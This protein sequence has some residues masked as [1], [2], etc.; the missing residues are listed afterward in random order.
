MGAVA[1]AVNAWLPQDAVVYCLGI[2]DSL[3]AF[4]DDDQA[5]KL[6]PEYRSLKKT[7]LR[8]ILFSQG[9]ARSGMHDL[10][11]VMKEYKD[12]KDLPQ[13]DVEPEDDASIFF[14]SGEYNCCRPE[15]SH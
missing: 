4:V 6:E 8:G 5:K 12:F 1:V 9:S 2:S 14:T 10:M 13:V 15:P 3:V 7:K 11:H